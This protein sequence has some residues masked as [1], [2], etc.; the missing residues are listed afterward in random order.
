MAIATGQISIIDY[1][2]ALTL[3]GFITSNH[4]KTQVYNPDNDTFNPDW[5]STN[6]VLTASLF[7]LGSGSDIIDISAIQS[8]KWYDGSDPSSVLSDGG[9]YGVNGKTLTISS[10]ILAT[11]NAVD[12]ICEVVYRDSVTGLDLTHKTSISFG[13]VENG[14]GITSTVAWL[15]EGNIFKNDGVTS[16]VAEADLWRGGTVDTTNITYQWY[17]QDPTVSTDQGGGTGWQK[18]TSTVNDGE[19][20]YTSRKITIPADAVPNF[21]VYKIIITDTDASSST[22]GQKFPDTVTLLDQSDPIQVSI[23]SPGGNVFKNGVGSTELTA[24]LFRAGQQI[25]EAGTGYTYNW[26]KYDKDGVLDSAFNQTGKAITVG[27][28]DV[29]TKATF[30]CEVE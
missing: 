25:D 22:N 3:T 2:D 20:G 4:A 10:N 16:L 18:I 26:Y 15:P 9:A 12:F 17:K 8:I 13:K 27:S 19:T 11:R 21:E 30:I 24:Q 28:N 14:G 7:K 29:A 1:N 6:L 5:S 23:S